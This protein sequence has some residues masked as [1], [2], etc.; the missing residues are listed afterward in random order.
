MPAAQRDMG[1]ASRARDAAQEFTIQAARDRVAIAV[2]ANKRLFP[3]FEL[4]PGGALVGTGRVVVADWHQGWVDARHILK[5]GEMRVVA[6]SGKPPLPT[7]MRANRSG[8]SAASRRPIS[9][10]QS[11][12]TRVM[13]RRPSA[14]IH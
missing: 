3:T 7:T 5:A 8:I 10:P 4:A 9:E 6:P 11:W 2:A 14:S 12:H 1:L 13:P